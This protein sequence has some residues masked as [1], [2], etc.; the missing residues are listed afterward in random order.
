MKTFVK[1]AAAAALVL[2][3][4]NTMAQYAP[5]A[6]DVSAEVQ[7]N[8]FGNAFNTFKLEDNIVFKV[9]TFLT[10]R[11]ALRLK[12]GL[13]FDNNSDV[14]KTAL[15]DNF[16]TNKP[17]YTLNNQEVETNNMA[18]YFDFSIGY[19]RHFI[20]DGRLDVYAGAEFGYQSQAFSGDVTTT[21]NNDQMIG[22]TGN[23]TRTETTSTYK[24]VYEKQSTDGS[25]I[26]SHGFFIGAFTGLDF[27][28]YK[29][30]YVGT[31]LGIRFSS[32]TSRAIPTITADY[33][34][35]VVT[36]NTIGST[37]TVNTRKTTYSESSETG[38][39]VGKT[40]NVAGS[41]TT[42]TKIEQAATMTD[43]ERKYSGLFTYI[44]PALRLGWKF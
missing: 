4:S 15:T 23:T 28:I 25:R 27:Y 17:A 19:E 7:F 35:T 39:R 36:T 38:Q 2:V 21:I 13:Q 26:N 30:L 22:T 41:T 5:E 31:E 40:V 44:T 14:T 20:N 6:G 29:G 8:P 34:G 43:V 10:D 9:R 42:E 3:S 16:D 1:F 11:D 18:T 24:Q 32:Y 12:V 37:S 33:N